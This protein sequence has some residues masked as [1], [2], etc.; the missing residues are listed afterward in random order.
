MSVFVIALV[1]IT[2]YV[3]S[4]SFLNVL[5]SVEPWISAF[6]QIPDSDLSVSVSCLGR[7]VT[8]VNSVALSKVTVIS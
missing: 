7:Y 8:A 3:T 2:S 1:F 4:Q 5:P 6:F